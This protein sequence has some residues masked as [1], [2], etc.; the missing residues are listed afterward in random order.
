MKV[1]DI[2]RGCLVAD[3]QLKDDHQLSHLVSNLNLIS[4]QIREALFK[5]VKISSLV[6]MKDIPNDVKEGVKKLF[7]KMLDKL[8]LCVVLQKQEMMNFLKHTEK[9]VRLTIL[10]QDVLLQPPKPKSVAHFLKD[11]KSFEHTYK[12]LRNLL[13][14]PR[15]VGY[16]PPPPLHCIAMVCECFM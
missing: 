14:S 2:I 1:K 16:T 13:G 4:R 10:I 7:D 9:I 12:E 3:L 6:E 11:F 15:E 8:K 5:K